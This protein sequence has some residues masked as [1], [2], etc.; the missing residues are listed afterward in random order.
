VRVALISQVT[1]AVEGYSQLLRALGHDLAGVL[2]VR[3]EG[4][5]V[6]FG[7]H[8]SAVAQELD[9]VV[10][11][12]RER[13]APLL[14]ALEPDVA[15]CLGFPWKLTAEMIAVPPL[16][17]VNTHPSLLPRHRGPVPVSWAIRNGE[18]EIGMTLHRMDTGL[19]TGPILAQEAIPL[20]DEHS[21]DELTPKFADAVGRLLPIA[22]ERVAAGDPGDPQDEA[23]ATYETFFEPE[24]CE[25]DWARPAAEI[26]R[27]V[28][29]LRFGGTLDSEPGALA[30]LDGE[31]V[32]VLR[33][34]LEPG[35][36]REVECGDG[37]VWIVESEPV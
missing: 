10:P 24:Y 20:A 30:E 34:S 2:C 29:A 36:G 17:I 37:S 13:F 26:A 23:A 22:L 32:R 4:R 28:R 12:T 21:W 3:T 16:G 7:G 35:D 8:V 1:P 18:P 14:Q 5:Y 33:V 31:R 27:Q 9:V 11:S 19:D 25:I 15:I 6:E